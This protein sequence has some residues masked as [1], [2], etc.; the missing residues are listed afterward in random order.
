M[1]ETSKDLTDGSIV[2]NI[3]YLALPMMVGNLFQDA[4]T[5]V[6]MIFVGK[7]GPSAIAAVGMSGTIQ[8]MLLSL[9]HI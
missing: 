1:R 7:L 5:I 4:F 2:R 3:W 8:G 9:I 6:D